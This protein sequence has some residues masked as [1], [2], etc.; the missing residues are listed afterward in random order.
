MTDLD[1][2]CALMGQ[3]WGQKGQSTTALFGIERRPSS[4]AQASSFLR[5]LHDDNHF[6]NC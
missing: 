5:N 6:L 2:F 3:I 4:F 1:P